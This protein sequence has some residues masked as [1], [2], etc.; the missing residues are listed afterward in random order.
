MQRCTRQHPLTSRQR[1][2][3]HLKRDEVTTVP[4]P[5]PPLPSP[6]HPPGVAPGRLDGSIRK[7]AR[8][9]QGVSIRQVVQVGSKQGPHWHPANCGRRRRLLPVPARFKL[10]PPP[11][12]GRRGSHGAHCPLQASRPR[13]THD[14]ARTR[15]W[16]RRFMRMSQPITPADQ[17]LAKCE[18]LRVLSGFFFEEAALMMKLPKRHATPWKGGRLTP[19]TLPKI[20]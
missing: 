1:P 19:R 15:T 10:P 4:P 8:P 20:N 11:P 9:K 14:R 6:F 7:I 3:P 18:I 17:L 16:A 13:G 12:A 5:P 2:T